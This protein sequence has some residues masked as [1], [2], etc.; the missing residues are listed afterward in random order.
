MLT[1]LVIAT[2][3]DSAG[4]ILRVHH[5]LLRISQPPWVW[6]VTHLI[7]NGVGQC[8]SLQ[9]EVLSVC[10]AFPMFFQPGFQG[11]ELQSN[12]TKWW[13]Q[14]EPWITTWRRAFLERYETLISL[15]EEE[16]FTVGRHRY[17]VCFHGKLA[18]TVDWWKQ[19]ETLIVSTLQM[20]TLRQN[21]KKDTQY[22]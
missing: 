11:Q 17:W 9:A 13:A 22:V 3:W 4:E 5:R 6:S 7:L 18:W 19:V 10:P 20:R 12:R 21:K 1:D 2:T 14:L 16:M 8:V 15:Y